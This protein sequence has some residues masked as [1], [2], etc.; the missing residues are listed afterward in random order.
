MSE[1]QVNGKIEP[2]VSLVN[3]KKSEGTPLILSF[4]HSGNR[5]PDDFKPN[6]NLS[7]EV[8]DFSNDSFVDELYV[9]KSNLNLLSIIANFPRIYIDVNRHQHPDLN[10]E[11]E[12]L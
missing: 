11:R 4:P 3:V 10:L 5:Y 8:L 12:D 9:F 7:F 1:I 2:S 6:P